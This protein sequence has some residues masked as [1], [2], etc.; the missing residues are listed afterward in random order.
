MFR[1]VLGAGIPPVLE[2]GELGRISPETIAA[3]E[4]ATDIVSLISEY[5]PLKRSGKDF[6]ALCPFHNEKTP[7]FYVS[8]SKQIY[9]CFGCGE[10]GNVF[11]FVMAMEKVSFTEAVRVL[12]ERA[13]IRVE[14]EIGPPAAGGI[15]KE[16][17]YRANDWAA[18][19]YERHLWE[20]ERGSRAREYLAERGFGEEVARRFRLGFAPPVRDTLLGA[21]GHRGGAA[22][23]VLEKAG[24]VL[25]GAGGERYDRF[26]GRLM[27]PIS[28]VRGRVIG[29][30]GRTLGD[31]GPKY[32]NSP[33]TPIFSKGISLYGVDLAKRAALKRREIF[34]MEGYTDVLAAF[35]SGVEAAV[36]TLGTA[37]TAGHV[38]L[39]RRFADRVY[40][41]FDADFAGEAASDRGLDI[42]LA[43]ELEALVL[44]LP[45]GQDPCDFLLEHGGEEF[46]K[47]KASAKEIFDFKVEL[48]SKRHDLTTVAGQSRALDEI[49]A[50]VA[51][52]PAGVKRE[53]YVARNALLGDL[54]WRLGI[55]EQ[56]LRERLGRFKKGRRAGQ[57][58]VGK[59]GVKRPREE[60]WL[61]ESLLAEPQLVE[62]AATHVSPEDLRDADLATILGAIYEAARDGR[63]I[64]AASLAAAVGEAGLGA[65]VVELE[66]DSARYSEHERRMAD[67]IAA[68]EARRRK[69]RR[70][71]LR[72]Q[73]GEKARQGDVDAQNG[74][75][76]E[77]QKG[78]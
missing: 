71:H 46:Q 63:D 31:E 68:I 69:A 55:S 50:T 14:Q 20:D 26:R 13:G 11:G 74:L 56:A 38:R 77:I 40:L 23:D 30:G 70:E 36:A 61:V 66:E 33:E 37:L 54:A 76:R 6:K 19:E 65:L 72:R 12:A 10:G 45:P 35:Q 18:K 22:E 17:L 43:E 8:P 2:W 62:T 60:R 16:R 5:I 41:V 44:R 7:S 15:D 57:A 67:C 47:F 4:Q 64:G 53:L 21:L 29:F 58:E 49:L 48:A 27:F 9:K 28:D 78:L 75:L 59:G 3:V 73:L 34:V 52:V 51:K 25:T 39:L 24:L 32:L 1:G 42:F